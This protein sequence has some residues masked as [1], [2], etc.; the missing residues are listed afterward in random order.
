MTLTATTPASTELVDLSAIKTVMQVPYTEYFVADARTSQGG[1]SALLMRYIA[2]AAGP[3]TI[4]M[5][6]TGC[7]YVANTSYYTTPW[8]VPWMHT[9]LGSARPGGPGARGRGRGVCGQR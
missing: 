8:V 7:M 5:G 6:S 3:R 1:E 2:K 4:V 9:Q